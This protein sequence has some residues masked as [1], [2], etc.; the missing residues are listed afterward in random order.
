MFFATQRPKVSKDDAY[1]K[2]LKELEERDSRVASNV[3][4]PQQVLQ[5]LAHRGDSQ[6]QRVRQ[7]PRIFLKIKGESSRSCEQFEGKLEI[8]LHADRC[9]RTAENFRCLCT[10]EKGGALWFQGNPFHRIIRGF[11][12]QAGDITDEDGN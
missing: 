11:M 5:Q 1:A 2:L 7:N 9:P 10:G 6:E 8:E 4:H 3:A 12:A